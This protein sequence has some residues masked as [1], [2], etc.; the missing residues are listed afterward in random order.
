MAFTSALVL[1]RIARAMCAISRRRSGPSGKPD[2]QQDPAG[3]GE[4]LQLDDVARGGRRRFM[5]HDELQADR[6]VNKTRELDAHQH[7]ALGAVPRLRTRGLIDLPVVAPMRQPKGRLGGGIGRRH[8]VRR[9]SAFCDAALGRRRRAC[10]LSTFPPA[11][12]HHDVDPGRARKPATQRRVGVRPTHGD[13]HHPARAGRGD[14]GSGRRV[15]NSLATEDLTPTLP[16]EDTEGVPGTVPDVRVGLRLKAAV[17]ACARGPSRLGGIRWTRK[18]ERASLKPL[19][20]AFFTDA[21]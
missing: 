7:A 8:A 9:L 13:D 15:R 21:L 11:P 3:R 5:V 19:D 10:V 6:R 16:E 20:D 1:R 17:A 18:G 12:V 2:G 4:G 14:A